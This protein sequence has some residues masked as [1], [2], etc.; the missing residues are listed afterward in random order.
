[1][2]L[3]ALVLLAPSLAAQPLR[4]PAVPL[5]AHD[6][7]F[8]I[9]SMTDRLTP[10]WTGKPNSLAALARI[11]GKTNASSAFSKPGLF[12]PADDRAPHGVSSGSRSGGAEKAGSGLSRGGE[13]RRVTNQ[14]P[15]D[16][17]MPEPRKNPIPPQRREGAEKASFGWFGR[18]VGYRHAASLAS[19]AASA[20]GFRASKRLNQRPSKVFYTEELIE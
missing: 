5:V 14:P 13:I 15:S 9:R 19:R 18:R 3:F 10:H 7:S 11:D 16:S 6:P 4:P 2:T 12:L 1:L 8:S 17:A 20:S